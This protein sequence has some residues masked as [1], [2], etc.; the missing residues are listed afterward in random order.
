GSAGVEHI[1]DEQDV[2]IVDRETDVG[3]FDDRL[4]TAAVEIVAVEGD[5]DDP[6]GDLDV[7]DDADVLGEARGDIDTAGANPDEDD[8]F[9]AFVALEHLVRHAA[10]GAFDRLRVHDDPL[11]ASHDEKKPPRNPR[12][13]SLSQRI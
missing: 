3:T 6:G 9:G 2:A 13:L 10:Q 4:L 1:I 5:V 11:V 12:R 8:A 7:F